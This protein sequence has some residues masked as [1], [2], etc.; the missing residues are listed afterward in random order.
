MVR[1]FHLIGLYLVLGTSSWL[2]MVMCFST[3]WW[4]LHKHLCRH[5]YVLYM[6]VVSHSQTLFNLVWLRETICSLYTCCSLFYKG[7]H[8]SPLDVVS[9]T[10]NKFLKVTSVSIP[11]YQLSYKYYSVILNC[12]WTTMCTRSLL[13]NSTSDCLADCTSSHCPGWHHW[14]WYN[15][16]CAHNWRAT[17]AG[18]P[19]HLWGSSSLNHHRGIW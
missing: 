3:R 18:W 4:G 15:L 2:R 10:F 7:Y 13:A 19:L 8:S 9:M 11:C 14:W 16:Q 12:V 5:T 17:E 1:T 6:I